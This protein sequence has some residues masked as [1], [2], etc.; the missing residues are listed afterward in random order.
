MWHGKGPCRLSV[1]DGAQLLQRLDA[2]VGHVARPALLTFTLHLEE[3]RAR[4]STHHAK[5]HMSGN[6][7]INKTSVASC[8]LEFHGM[9]HDSNCVIL[10]GQLR[11]HIA[12]ALVSGS[13]SVVFYYLWL[14]I[15]VDVA[16]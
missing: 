15:W 5:G 1:Q 16:R 14:E 9:T 7:I 11:G 10:G 8:K 4:H 3:F 12:R 13:Q 6:L 2:C